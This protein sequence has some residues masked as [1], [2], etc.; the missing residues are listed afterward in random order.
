MKTKNYKILAIDDN[1]DNLI[2]IK[3]VIEEIL[4]GAKVLTANNGKDGIYIARAEDPDVIL[5]DI[6][7]PGMDGFEVCKLMKNDLELSIIPILFLTALKTD[8]AL[9]LKT[10][11]AGG[12]GFLSK[13]LD[14]TEM[15]AQIIA[16]SKIK[17]ANVMQRR[18]REHLEEVVAERTKAIETELLKRREIES[19]LK[20][21]ES[22]YRRLFETSKDGILVLN[23]ESCEIVDVNFALLKLFGCSKEDLIGKTIWEI[24]LFIEA[25]NVHALFTDVQKLEYFFCDELAVQRTDNKS[26]SIEFSSNIFQA[27]D[28][29]VI[30]CTIRDISER[31]HRQEQVEYLSYHD[32]LTGL[33]NRRFFE[34]EL[35][36]MDSPDNLPISIFMAD[37]NG[38]KLV[39]DSLGHHEGD[40]LL[41]KV[42]GMINK[43][44]RGN[45]IV[46]RLGGDEFVVALPRTTTDRAKSII[47]QIKSEL[48]QDKIDF[49]DLSVS[50]G[51]A[52]KNSMDEELITVLSDA[53]NEM[54]KSKM[55]ESASMRSKMILLIMNTLFEKSNRELDHSK[56]VSRICELIAR[57]MQFSEEHINQIKTAGLVHDIGKIGISE[58]ILNKP[59][60]LTTDEWIE[61]KKHPDASWR[62][63]S[64]VKEFAELANFVSEH[65]ERWDG[66]GY[67]KG[68]KGSEISLEARIIALADAYDAMTSKR[69]YRSA[70]SEDEAVD[71]IKRHAGLQFD[72]VI[73]KIFVE[74]VLSK[75]W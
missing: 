62:I 17:E 5:L 61:M 1:L 10:L 64:G 3:A 41:K 56:R 70:L 42:A 26:I 14:Q 57:Q 46:S 33:Y 66:K 18:Q 73:S 13:P 58:N 65:H 2:T 45:D 22:R 68:L 38:L 54:Y 52:G 21:S 71:E 28:Q 16:M 24:G 48:A 4:P 44:C 27:G 29:K 43:S 9:R 25:E 32:H 15:M 19:A 37:I 50:F 35:E 74:K 55:Y 72:K 51:C 11:E 39:N 6:V 20:I 49:L 59:G 40:K 36:K 53:E 63:L 31:K 7:M 75:T 8:R 30:Q 47:N 23:A 60:K 34:E 67:P 69:S 12:E